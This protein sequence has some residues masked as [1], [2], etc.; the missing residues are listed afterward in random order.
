MLKPVL[1][2]SLTLLVHSGLLVADE[3]ATTDLDYELIARKYVA[4][5]DKDLEAQAKFYT[6]ETRFRD[7]TSDLFGEPWDITGGNQIISFLEKASNDSGTLN[8]DYKV[9]NVLTE[10][11]LV[12]MNIIANV[13]SCGVGIGF[14]NKSFTGDIH[15]LMILNFDGEKIKERTDYVGY[16]DAWIILEEIQKNLHKKEDDH[17]CI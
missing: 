2:L 13:T 3:P 17:R 5:L 1:I 7:P 14:P 12:I 16:S 4:T 10:R 8:V 6:S 9:T 15:M 11:S